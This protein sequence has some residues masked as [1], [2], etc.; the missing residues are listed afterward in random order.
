MRCI[1]TGELL[2]LFRISRLTALLSLLFFVSLMAQA[3]QNPSPMVEHTREHAR[4]T[5][6]LPPGRR[7]TLEL[8]SLFVPEKVTQKRPVKLLLFFH[9]GDWLPEVAVAQQRNMAVIP[10]QAG[11]GSS[12]YTKLFEDPARFPR[13]IAE[14]EAK[15]GL[16]FSEIDLGGWSAGCGALRQIL[17]DPASYDRVSRVLC[18]D[19]VHTGYVNG[20]P[21]PEE[22]KIETDN[23]QV[24]LRLGRDGM[25]GKKRLIITHSEIFPGTFA[26]TTE[27]ADYLLR[28]WGLAAH[29]V[30]QWGPMK[31][32]MLSEVRMGGLLVVG[33]AGNSAPDHVDQFHS[34][35]EYLNWLA[36]K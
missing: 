4:L 7:L 29:P 21:G 27:T 6:I 12:T 2:K 14:A 20:T 19:G 13:L 22:S 31:T 8:G 34:L 30:V 5:K 9:G 18:I 33:F 3:Q 23:L 26:S 35:P 24:W 16:K 1:F 36:K 10:I 11:A 28:E 25:A 32:Q 15:S 17:G